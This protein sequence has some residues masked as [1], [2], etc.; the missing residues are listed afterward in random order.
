MLEIFTIILMIILIS[1]YVEGHF[2]IPFV[3][4]MIVLAYFANGLHNLSSLGNNFQ[5]IIYLMLPTILLPD[6][7]GFNRK[8]LRHHA[9]EISYLALLAVVVSIAIGVAITYYIPNQYNFS[10][11]ALMILFTPLMA[12]DIISVSAIFSKFKIPHN[13]KLLAEGESLFNDITAMIIFFFIAIPMMKGVDVTAAELTGIAFYTVFVSIFIG[14]VV[15]YIGY[16]AF[17]N[18]KNNFEE[19]IVIYVMTSVSFIMAEEMHLSGI[20]AVVAAIMT[21]RYRFDR[22][23]KLDNRRN[24]AVKK[25]KIS[26]ASFRSYNKGA[27]Y[28]ALFA[29]AV[30]FVTMA[31]VINFDILWNYRVEIIYVFLLTSIIRYIAILILGKVKKYPIR[32]VNILALSGMKGALAMIMV[33][34]L[35]DTFEY[36]ELFI[37]ITS[38]VVI[39]SIFIYTLLLL[40]Y[41][42]VQKNNLILD[43]FEEHNLEIKNIEDIYTR[44]EGTEAENQVIF[45]GFIE[46]EISMAEKNGAEFSLLAFK[47]DKDIAKEVKKY[48]GNYDYFG[49]IE[50]NVYG[51]LLTNRSISNALTLA[52]KINTMFNLKIVL[53]EYSTGDGIDMIYEKVNTGLSQIKHS[54]DVEI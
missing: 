12:T 45:E 7:M 11:Y 22:H 27:H 35:A 5:E 2:K 17:N 20:L 31:N 44:E 9:S 42:K 49:K 53:A 54:V 24:G 21:F 23:K 39:L 52:N 26:D 28:L 13:L 48:K 43:K 18:S 1:K 51:L 36:K 25:T 33:V 4:T 19:F 47:C 10:I 50:K 30:I 3:L 32:F 15:G 38:G 8:E 40:I 16:Y 6:V 14:M 37:A 46:R 29:N 41:L 34:S